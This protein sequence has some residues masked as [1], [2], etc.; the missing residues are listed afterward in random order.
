MSGAG[1]NFD[2]PDLPSPAKASSL[3]G[4]SLF[5]VLIV[6]VPLVLVI[7]GVGGWLY[8]QANQVVNEVHDIGA[9]L[10][11]A[12]KTPEKLDPRF[13]D[14]NDNLVADPPSD[15]K[16]WLDPDVLVFSTLGSS[17]REEAAWKDFITHLKKVTGKKE[18]QLVHKHYNNEKQFTDIARGDV[19]ML[20]LSTGAVEPA[21]KLGGFVPFCV[22]ADESGKFGYQMEIIVPKDSDVNSLADL[23][24]KKVAWANP[25]SHSGFKLLVVTLWDNG[26]HY[27]RD[28][29]YSICASGQAESIEAIRA[30]RCNA[31][32]VASD[33]LKRQVADGKISDNDY[34]I[35]YTSPHTYPPACF[36]YVYKLKPELA[37][38]IKKAFLDFNFA[39]TS[40]EKEY[41]NA[42]QVKFVPIS[43]KKD[44]EGIRET[45]KRFLQLTHEKP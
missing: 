5:N 44:W 22:M 4:F 34:K 39:G 29:S 27:E 14:A 6:A 2:T 41:K 13:T 17:A 36:G 40:L 8:M 25:S 11:Y 12:V 18:I 26:L 16:D 1:P 24:G 20:A 32:G 10:R 23:R 45:E 43:Y 28:Y 31:A 35:I 38:K 37:D 9:S 33:F 21:V 3:W 7:G 15:P 42:N 19:H 30:K